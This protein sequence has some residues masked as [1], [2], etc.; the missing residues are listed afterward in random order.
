MFIYA[1]SIVHNSHPHIVL[2]SLPPPPNPPHALVH[3]CRVYNRHTHTILKGGAQKNAICYPYPSGCWVPEL[4]HPQTGAP[5]RE[6]YIWDEPRWTMMSHPFLWVCD[7]KAANARNQKPGEASWMQGRP[8]AFAHPWVFSYFPWR[9]HTPFTVNKYTHTPSSIAWGLQCGW[10]NK[11]MHSIN[12][13]AGWQA[14]TGIACKTLQ[15][16]NTNRQPYRYTQLT[17]FCYTI[18]ENWANNFIIS[19]RYLIKQKKSNEQK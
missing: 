17:F 2:C 3:F 16:G 6:R 13:R 10:D 5:E 11:H 1:S 4:D 19:L 12:G 18:I 8:S 9:N 15:A 14:V 7:K